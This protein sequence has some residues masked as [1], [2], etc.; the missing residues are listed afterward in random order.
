[1]NDLERGKL[2]A[3]KAELSA[4]EDNS[5]WVKC[6]DRLPVLADASDTFEVFIFN[7]TWVSRHAYDFVK[8]VPAFTHW[9]PIPKLKLPDPPEGFFDD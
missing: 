6:S 2:K 4:K 3:V 5:K 1:M 9:M 7:G 8:Y